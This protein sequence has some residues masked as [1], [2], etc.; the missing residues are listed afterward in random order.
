MTKKLLFDII[1]TESMNS[2]FLNKRRFGMKHRVTAQVNL[3][4]IGHNYNYIKTLVGDARVMAVVKADAYG[5]GSAE[6]VKRLSE[7]GCTDFAV[8]CISEAQ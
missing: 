1:M 6:V 7:L 4:R 8:A 2:M 5:H 3:D